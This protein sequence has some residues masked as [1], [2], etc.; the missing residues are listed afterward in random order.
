MR[1]L[2]EAFVE[3]MDTRLARSLVLWNRTGRWGRDDGRYF[4]WHD[5]GDLHGVEHLL[6]LNRIALRCPGTAFWLP[7]KEVGT[8]NAALA[9]GVR[10]ASNLVVRLSLPLVDHVGIPPSYE[11]AAKLSP[12]VVVAN[13]H[14]DKPQSGFE[15]CNAIYTDHSCKECRRC[16]DRDATV[17]YTV[18]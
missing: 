9:D 15:Q 1:R 4:R 18:I 16:W 6:L 13:A 11:A 2:E 10:F 17:S 5:S 3:V 7:T 12:Q 8:V 14:R